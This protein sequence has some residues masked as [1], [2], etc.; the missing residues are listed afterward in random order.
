V[1]IGFPVATVV[2]V[3]EGNSLLASRL[4]LLGDALGA[5]PLSSLLRDAYCL[6]IAVIP[7]AAYAHRQRTI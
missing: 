4:L 5:S 2:T 1:P 6:G 3:A 7:S